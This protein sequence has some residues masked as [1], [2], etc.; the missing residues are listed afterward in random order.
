MKTKERKEQKKEE[1]EEEKTWR[2]NVMEY[3]AVSVFVTANKSKVIK[4]T[5]IQKWNE[6]KRENKNKNN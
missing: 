6:M 2:I 1:A 4:F 5:Y 3:N